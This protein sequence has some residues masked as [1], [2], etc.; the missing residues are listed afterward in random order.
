MQTFRTTGFVAVPFMLL[1]SAGCTNL[2][3]PSSAT[4]LEPG[5]AYWLSYDASRR[6]TV[7]VPANSTIKSCSEPAPDVGLS[8]AN[9]L[10]GGLELPSGAKV[11]DIE[12]ALNATAMALAG[13]DDVVLLAREALFRI[14]EA[15]LNGSISAAEVP[16]L[17]KTVFDAVKE[18]AV[19][20]AQKAEGEAKKAQAVLQTQTLQMQQQ[21]QEP[22]R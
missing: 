6:G 18:I 8:F 22:R 11:S 20:Q 2:T 3:S 13:R 1:A 17:L 9:S 4:V 15:N 12:V 7:V 21:Q 16:S 10:K 19:A 5:S 14:C